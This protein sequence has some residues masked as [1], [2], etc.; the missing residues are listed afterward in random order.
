MGHRQLLIG[1][2]LLA[3]LPAA[4]RCVGGPPSPPDGESAGGCET[5][6]DAVGVLPGESIQAA[7]D[8]HP[9]GTSFLLKAGVHR[10]QQIWP[11]EGD[12]FYGERDAECNRS[13]ILT[14]ARPPEND[15]EKVLDSDPGMVDEATLR[16]FQLFKPVISAI[17]GFAIA[18][19]M[20]IVQ[21]DLA[22]AAC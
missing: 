18:A 7:V 3:T 9:E 21:D 6:P 10:L 12:A 2:I 5:P 15:D 22:L 13:T 4:Y 16:D 8:S 19:G 14:G 1:L 11:K 20:E 17:N